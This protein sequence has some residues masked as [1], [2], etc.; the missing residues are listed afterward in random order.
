MHRRFIAVLAFAAVLAPLVPAQA[1]EQMLLKPPK[2]FKVVAESKTDT[3]STAVMVPDGQS[4]ANW[5]EKLTTQILFKQAEQSPADYRAHSE[6]AAAA[7]CPGAT[8]ETIKDGTENLYPM[9][10]WTE[11]CPKAKDGGKSEVIWSKAVRGRE[12]F[13][14]LQKAHRFEPNAKQRKA[15]ARLFDASRVCDTRVPGHRCKQK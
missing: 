7:E 1:L 8:F 4:A 10:T 14:L 11:T 5:T 13:Y 15:L 3:T 6:K 2:G 12:N 9:V